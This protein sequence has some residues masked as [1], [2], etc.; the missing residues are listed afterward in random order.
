M[1][2]R[3]DRTQEVAGSSPASSIRKRHAL[4]RPLVSLRAT[5]RGAWEQFGNGSG[6]RV[7]G[8]TP[9]TLVARGPGREV[10]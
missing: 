3:R 2:S 9:I 6:R 10:R 8:G 1:S 5:C 7:D 4:C